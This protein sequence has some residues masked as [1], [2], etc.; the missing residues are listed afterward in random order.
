MV[1]PTYTINKIRPTKP[2]K[3][4]ST[5]EPMNSSA[6]NSIPKENGVTMTRKSP[7]SANSKPI[8]VFYRFKTLHN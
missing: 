8:V 2:L 7:T 5:M 1:P 6:R 4:P 3:T